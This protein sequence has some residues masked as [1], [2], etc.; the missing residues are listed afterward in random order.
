MSEQIYATAKRDWAKSWL[1]RKLSG[2]V[3]GK[4]LPLDGA[5][6]NSINP[7]TGDVLT[8]LVETSPQ[9]VDVAVRAAQE[10]GDLA[11]ARDAAREH[12][13]IG[14]DHLTI[15]RVDA[16]LLEHLR[17]ERGDQMRLGRVPAREA[18]RVEAGIERGRPRDADRR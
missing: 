3:R 10:T 7:A 8:T 17:H 16:R 4:A 1:N 11:V 18:E 15:G 13:E 9:H 12:R 6:F 5:S 2:S 14:L